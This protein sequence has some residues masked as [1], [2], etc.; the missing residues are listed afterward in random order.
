MSAMK[1]PPPA[2]NIK[3]D[4]AGAIESQQEVAAAPSALQRALS[5]S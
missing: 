2:L 1:D 3:D 5:S 4:A